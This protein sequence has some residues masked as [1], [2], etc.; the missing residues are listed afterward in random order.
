[1]AIRPCSYCRPSLLTV[2]LPRQ[3]G[4]FADRPVQ[5]VDVPTTVIHLNVLE[6]LELRLDLRVGEFSYPQ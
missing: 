3:S 1:M 2:K 4:A 5:E 6:A